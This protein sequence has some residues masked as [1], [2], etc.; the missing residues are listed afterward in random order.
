[1]NFAFW[2]LGPT[3]RFEEKPGPQVP[4]WP[5]FKEEQNLC[6]T[7]N[8]KDLAA[9]FLRRGMDLQCSLAEPRVAQWLL[10][11]DDK[12]NMP[13]GKSM[14]SGFGKRRLQHLVTWRLSKLCW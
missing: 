11:P 3:N 13:L 5:R 10:D 2:F 7:S 14:A 4:N 6:L 9:A 8:A 12:Q 1:M